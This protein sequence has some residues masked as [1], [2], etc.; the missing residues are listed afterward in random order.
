MTEANVTH[1]EKHILVYNTRR[2]TIFQYII[3]KKDTNVT[4][5][6]TRHEVYLPAVFQTY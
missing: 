5:F 1:V 6:E 2:S 3:V 4:F